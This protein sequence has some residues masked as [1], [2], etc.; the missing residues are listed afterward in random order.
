MTGPLL[1][2][3]ASTWR[4]SLGSLFTA[5]ALGNSPTLLLERISHRRLQIRPDADDLDAVENALGKCPRTPATE[6]SKA[7]T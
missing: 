7:R 3:S 5:A 4:H 6:F 1:T 2:L